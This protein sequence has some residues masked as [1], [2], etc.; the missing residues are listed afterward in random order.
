[1]ILKYSEPNP[2][3]IALFLEGQAFS[4]SYDLAPRPSPP[5]LLTGEGWRGVG[6]E[7][8]HLTATK[9]GPL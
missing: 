6:E 4:R 3:R 2:E 8:N 9:P 5:S 7:P 1:M